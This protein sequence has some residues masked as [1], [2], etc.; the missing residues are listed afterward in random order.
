MN[1]PAESSSTARRISRGLVACV[2]ACWASL[3][4]WTVH[5]QGLSRW[6]GGGFGMYSEFHPTQNDAWVTVADQPPAHFVKN[7][8]SAH[9]LY[10]VVRPHLTFPRPTELAHSLDAVVTGDDGSVDVQITGLAFDLKTN[11]LSRRPILSV[12]SGDS[13]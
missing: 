10:P 3:Q 1:S 13:K 2:M 8:K 12:S 7:E 9:D 6:R 4:M 11:V 5:T